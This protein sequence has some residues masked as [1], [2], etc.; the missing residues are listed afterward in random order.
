MLAESRSMTTLFPAL[1]SLGL[2]KEHLMA[3]AK[4]GNVRAENAP[5]GKCYYKLRFRMG[6]RQHVR[7]VG[8][9]P[10][11]V[12]Q[13]RRELT[14][15]QAGT[16]SCRHLRRLM[17]EANECLRRTKEPLKP[18]LLLAGCC[19]HGRE[20]RRQ[21]EHDDRCVDCNGTPHLEHC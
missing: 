3:L 21:P 12:E 13:V 5:Q 15:L 16:K 19:F 17:R 9:N 20:I 8:N 1:A 6:L 18:L 11:F 10:E 7:Y 14:W 2:S 4:Q